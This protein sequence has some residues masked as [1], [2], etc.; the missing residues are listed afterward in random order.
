MTRARI[1]S[2]TLAWGA[3]VG[4]LALEARARADVTP[5]RVIEL[6][7]VALPEDV[8]APAGGVVVAVI[9]VAA[10]GAATVERCD[11]GDALCVLVR[12]ALARAT[13]EP[14]R[15]DGVAVDARIRVALRV[16]RP[17]EEVVEPATS[18][19]GVDAATPSLTDADAG[20]GDAGTRASARD[21]EIF[22]SLTTSRVVRRA[23]MRRLSLAEVRDLPGAF[24]DP[25]RAVDALPGVVPV[26][27][28]LP[29]FFIRGSPPAGTLYVYDDIAVP[30]LFHLAVGPAVI[31]PRMVGPIR[32]YSG[33]A[34]ARHGRLVGG[35]VVGEG[36]EPPDG[37]LHAEA[38][39][40]L[41]DVNGYVEA[42]VLG[43][44][45]AVAGRYGYPALLLSVFSPEV[46][47]AYWDYQLR[48]VRALGHGDRVELVALGSYDSLAVE[49]EP[50]SDIAIT[51]H[52][53]EA[54]FVRRRGPT[55]YGVA[56]LF[57]W[58]ESSLGT[59]LS[60]Q[61]TRFGPRG[62][63]E[64]RFSSRARARISAD[65]SGVIGTFSSTP[66]RGGDGIDIDE[67]GTSPL[68][69]DVP[70]RSLW[71]IALELALRPTS[72]MDIELGGRADA[73]LQGSG[74][75]GVL[76]PRARVVLHASRDLELH[77]AAGVVHQP[78]VF[79]VPLPGL[80]DVATDRGL[81]SALQTEVGVGWDAPGGIRAEAQ[82]FL[83][84][85]AGLVFA[86]VLFL[87]EA[88]D[89]IC[90]TVGCDD[91]SVPNRI[92]ALSY[93]LELFLRRAPEER[94]S[95]WL[96][97]T[98]SF[99]DAED[100]AGLPYTPSW[101]VRHVLNVVL[102]GDLVAGVSTGLRF[103]ARSGKMHGEFVLDD[104]LQLVRD[105]RRLP[106][107]VRFDIQVAYAW[108][109]SWGRL[110]VWLEWFNATLTREPQD[111][112]CEGSPRVCRVEY[113]PAIF[114]PSIG[115]RGEI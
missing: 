44:S 106:W 41:L 105:E 78:A 84:Q 20:V 32:L 96:S 40:R 45:L 65:A 14:A 2:M 98:L 53:L 113:L 92:D 89:R 81:Q 85:Y 25:F 18:D 103:H 43:G 39:V 10:D 24:G 1:T 59:E 90:V 82:L 58:E 21:D 69:G 17:T 28:G 47:L 102:Q 71:G 37:R 80:A 77:V 13:F 3:I 93:G 11:A 115:I 86:D 6:P 35:V 50:D 57:G 42:P 26:L 29:Y 12:D 110:R 48:F 49:D 104:A 63:I 74:V 27:S 4:A 5:P 97:Y 60:L 68:F 16:S 52:R 22:E 46:D 55:T 73:W 33:V 38:E 83:H 70:A 62:W 66:A 88:L 87:G 64:H 56:M 31:H 99:A 76:D 15:R 54:R 72:W 30:T 8:E 67:S 51:F 94:L 61:A 111:I 114:F 95:G 107:F 7:D 19:G 91:A 79:F 34:P 9:V 108:R 112:E 36:P 101:D 75:E 23:G 109:T 100:V